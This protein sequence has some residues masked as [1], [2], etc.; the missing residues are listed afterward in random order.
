[1]AKLQSRTYKSNKI[2]ENGTEE[3]HEKESFSISLPYN[4]VMK[5]GWKKGDDIAIV[6]TEEK[7][8]KLIK[9]Y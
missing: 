5:L 2:I 7:A 4:L 3:I 8:M 1:M 9:A 6:L